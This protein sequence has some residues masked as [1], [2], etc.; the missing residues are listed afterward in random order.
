MG[1]EPSTIEHF[2]SPLLRASGLCFV[3][4]LVHADKTSIQLSSI[5]VDFCPY[6]ARHIID[7]QYLLAWV[8]MVADVFSIVG[9]CGEEEEGRTTKPFS[10]SVDPRLVVL[11][12]WVK[13]F[14]GLTPEACRD[15][16]LIP[17]KL[18]F[19]ASCSNLVRCLCT[20]QQAIRCPRVGRLGSNSQMGQVA[21]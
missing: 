18:C 16:A 8:V 11:V 10:V 7:V 14:F 4:S 1:A 2:Y 12:D 6:I 5:A 9:G 20:S 17:Q 21:P 3:T 15:F 19:A 13:C